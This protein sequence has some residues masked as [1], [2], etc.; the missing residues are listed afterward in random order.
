MGAVAL[1]A[2]LALLIIVS[3]VAA[4]RPA[5]PRHCMETA[6]GRFR[7]L[8]GVGAFVGFMA[9][10]TGM[11]GPVL[12]VPLMILM[13]FPPIATVA[14]AQPFQMAACFSGSIGNIILGQIDWFIAITSV[15]LQSLGVWAGVCA[16]RRMPTARLKKSIAFLCVF[17]G[18]LMLFR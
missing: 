8:L 11:G 17:T 12:S 13:S 4:L 16:A 14:A 7:Y 15:F 6:R 18:V 10:L 3:G 5:R 2:I 1:N 9:G